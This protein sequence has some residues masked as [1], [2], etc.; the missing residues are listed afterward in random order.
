VIYRPLFDHLQLVT[1]RTFETVAANTIP[2]FTQDAAFV[3]EVYGAS[4]EELVLGPHGAEK[5][6]DVLRRSDYYADIVREMRCHLAAQHSYAARIKEL[7][8]IVA[9]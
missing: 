1:C 8:E 7:M 5:I 4:A 6:L 9:S 2:L 3:R